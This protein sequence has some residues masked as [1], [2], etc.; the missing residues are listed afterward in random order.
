MLKQEGPIEVYERSR[1]LF[2]KALMDGVDS[3][4]AAAEYHFS[5]LNMQRHG[6][7][8]PWETEDWTC[9]QMSQVILKAGFEGI[10]ESEG[11]LVD[12]P[13]AGR[14]QPASPP[15]TWDQGQ[16]MSG[17]V[18]AGLLHGAWPTLR[19]PQ[20]DEDFHYPDEHPFHED[21]HPL[22]E[23]MQYGTP[24]FVEQLASFYLRPD[25][26]TPSLSEKTRDK[27]RIYE[28]AHTNHPAL[29]SS[30]RTME[31]HEP[32]S[33][34]EEP[35]PLPEEEEGEIDPATFYQQYF[36]EQEGVPQDEAERDHPR[37]PFLGPLLGVGEGAHG[38][39]QHDA[40]EH[41]YQNWLAS[42][43]ESKSGR[44][45][46][47]T[48]EEHSGKKAEEMDWHLRQAHFNDMAYDWVHGD[49][50]VDP[51]GQEHATKLGWLGYNLGLEFM[52]PD[53]RTRTVEH[54]ME[55]GSDYDQQSPH[56]PMGRLKRNFHQRATPEYL[57]WYRQPA[58]HGPN[59]HQLPEVPYDIGGEWGLK[60]LGK[61][62]KETFLPD[63]RSVHDA[64]LDS[65]NEMQGLTD[66][67]EQHVRLPRV[68]PKTGEIIQQNLFDKEDA[69][70]Q[71]TLGTHT[72]RMLAGFDEHGEA[73]GP[74]EHPLHG[75]QWQ[76][77]FMSPEKYQEVLA[78]ADWMSGTLAKEKDIRNAAIAH[79]SAFGPSKADIEAHD[80]GDWWL[81]DTDGPHTETFA[82]HWHKP[83]RHGGLNRSPMSYAEMLHDMTT[84]GKTLGGSGGESALPDMLREEAQ[85][86]VDMENRR[87]RRE[88]GGD[89]YEELQVDEDHI[90]RMVQDLVG[91][92]QGRHLSHS[93]F[94]TG[95]HRSDGNKQ[96][97]DLR[98]DMT[99]L[100]GSILP[101]ISRDQPMAEYRELNDMGEILNLWEQSG[102]VV[103]D[104]L[105]PVLPPRAA[106][107]NVTLT[108]STHHPEFVQ[109][110][111]R[112]THAERT[113]DLGT[114]M[115]WD[116]DGLNMHTVSPY[117]KMESAYEGH[118]NP[119]TASIMSHKLATILGR[120]HSPSD[121]MQGPIRSFDDVLR[122]DVP[123]EFVSHGDPE[124]WALHQG[125]LESGG[126]RGGADASPFTMDVL[127]ALREMGGGTHHTAEAVAQK[128][129]LMEGEPDPHADA[130]AHAKWTEDSQGAVRGVR[131]A[132][133]GLK[134]AA[135]TPEEEAMWKRASSLTDQVSEMQELW[136]Q[137]I[138]SGDQQLADRYT[139]ALQ[140]TYGDLRQLE[141]T[142]AK[143]PSRGKST[144][145]KQKWSW[146]EHNKMAESHMGA[147]T[148]VAKQ[149]RGQFEK[150]HP[151]LF[152]EDDPGQ[153]LSNA[154]QTFR[155]AN[156]YLMDMD[157]HHHGQT[158]RGY[159]V[160]ATHQRAL[161]DVLGDDASPFA[162]MAEGIRGMEGRALNPNHTEEEAME[163]L[164]LDPKNPVHKK[165]AKKVL[166][167]LGGEERIPVRLSELYNMGLIPN[168]EP[169]D[170]DLHQMARGGDRFVHA[171]AGMGEKIFR[172]K[173]DEAAQHGLQWVSSEPHGER[174]K[175]RSSGGR[176][177]ERAAKRRHNDAL[178]ASEALDSFVMLDPKS[179]G[180][181]GEGGTVSRRAGWHD[182]LPIHPV[183]PNGNSVLDLLDS[184]RLNWGWE[185]SPDF[186]P[187][188]RKDGTS[189][190]LRSGQPV[191]TRLHSV[192]A[193]HLYAAF[194]E[195]AELMRG[196]SFHLRQPNQMS[197]SHRGTRGLAADDDRT[198]ISSRDETAMLFGLT[199][200][201]AMLY[202]EDSAPD[203]WSP[204]IRPMH[205]IFEKSD[206]EE[207]RGF[208]GDWVVS[209]WP[210][211]ERVILRKKGERVNAY[212]ENG[213]SMKLSDDLVDG[214]KRARDGGFVADAILHGDDLLF[215]DLLKEGSTDVT[216]LPLR[217][218]VKLLRAHF[219]STEHV[220]MP[221]P[222]NTRTS[223]EEGLAKALEDLASD[224]GALILRDAESTYMKGERRHPKWVLLRS[225]KDVNL[226]V[227]DRRGEGPYT[228]RLGAGPLLRSEDLGNRSA[229]V[230]GDT[231]MDVG[232]LFRSSE[233][234]NVGDIVKLNVSSVSQRSRDGEDIF[235]VQGSGIGEGFGEGP[236]SIETLSMLSKSFPPLA[237]PHRVQVVGVEDNGFERAVVV[238]LP[239]LDDDVIYK[240]H[241]WP[242]GWQVHSPETVMGDLGKG[243]YPVRLAESLR[244]FWSPVVAAMLK[245]MC[246]DPEEKKEAVVEDKGDE[247]EPLIEPKEVKDTFH[248]PKKEELLR[249][250][251]LALR[252]LDLIAK[253]RVTSTG[254][255]G[256]GLD[257]GTPVE[258]P[259]GPTK[260]VNESAL[261]DWDMRERPEE[262][263]EKPW[264]QQASPPS[265]KEKKRPKS[266]DKLKDEE[267]EDGEFVTD[268]EGSTLYI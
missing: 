103:G 74:G 3:R 219:D 137:A 61:A 207:L 25:P 248:K 192:P 153:F 10:R 244:P 211:G 176:G 123:P 128:M 243:D 36:D 1:S 21:T 246:L 154:L 197:M 181:E 73:Y 27:E 42:P 203:D 224:D 215:V 144:S 48:T 49:S 259:R 206:L 226:M 51:A 262:D 88:A 132:M 107:H 164:G 108:T 68:H 201:D 97:L 245:G 217:E 139:E 258:S 124:I 214:I 119:R 92:Q 170:G 33:G 227:L 34:T 190:V 200:P 81:D 196:Q 234:F 77:P 183:T 247:G 4:N 35:E 140:N 160:K 205:R 15:A 165:N 64:M 172:F 187:R 5:L 253:E 218:R 29:L 19:P 212:D 141:Q 222:F 83:F 112:K 249:G 163:I 252:A 220:Q 84:V 95:H 110:A 122:G 168:T 177:S 2:A 186:I 52:T 91:E 136:E 175:Q 94:G 53:E 118:I 221:A 79:R 99:G 240:V 111:M 180:P 208:S 161:G 38:V 193:E 121:P 261:P 167:A 146:Q 130:D 78:K 231:Y 267:G 159:A 109:E 194:P 263:P 13:W 251:A 158:G 67:E 76:A 204:P 90:N 209:E 6:A 70:P 69:E 104:D 126:K 71:P 133:A 125:W 255:R 59:L 242:D 98:E 237:W 44:L 58:M 7:I 199:D 26:N 12:F 134:E 166:D 93:F 150:D 223:D 86:M 37:S 66:T 18:E 106:K 63:G 114:T 129:G 8:Y 40:Y 47:G 143:S 54:L 169:I 229:D 225:S 32:A 182:D 75:A 235:T 213:A 127:G 115:N 57:W 17:G 96:T 148:E 233:A 89:D 156:R 239:S 265:P 157:H 202:K 46:Q 174:K 30:R 250:F 151:D 11:Q 238:S 45:V 266:T 135:P 131:D 155:F 14:I 191:P 254:A 22:L 120:L 105:K 60:T 72:L 268:D 43:A 9:Q 162:H 145:G 152:P 56:V 230:L 142:L 189:Q 236:A 260:L 184:D 50:V 188:Y 100:M 55:N 241:E 179:Q 87:R 210:E 198:L 16:Q 149:L 264:E 82:S 23:G 20:P 171:G 101:P 80:L 185:M 116:M 138:A 65:V 102:A 178:K 117:N 85:R 173:G 41:H 228:Y 216:D 39:H 113:K 257:H 147:I 256:M 62:S 195:L 31:D 24:Q 28:K 232:T